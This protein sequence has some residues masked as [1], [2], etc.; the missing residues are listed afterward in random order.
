M[1]LFLFFLSYEVDLYQQISKSFDLNFDF[2]LN[3]IN[4]TTVYIRH[5]C[6]SPHSQIMLISTGLTAEL[7]PSLTNITYD[8]GLRL[9]S[10][11]RKMSSAERKKNTI[12]KKS[13]HLLG[14]TVDIF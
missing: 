5:E 4:H 3:F 9:H 7:A 6:F 10:M 14:L 1:L 2:F 13:L 11:Y 8:F 12:M